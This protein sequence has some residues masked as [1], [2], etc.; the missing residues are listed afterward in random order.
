MGRLEFSG[1]E[2]LPKLPVDHP[3]TTG[4]DM[5]PRRYRGRISGERYQVFSPFDLHSQD[6][7]TIL[8]VM[9]GDAIDESIQRFGHPH[10]IS[11]EILDHVHRLDVQPQFQVLALLRP[12]DLK[13]GTALTEMKMF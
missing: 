2:L 6:G 8:R 3:A 13:D 7:E 5:F 12:A 11:S 1:L 4:L 10:T 9:V